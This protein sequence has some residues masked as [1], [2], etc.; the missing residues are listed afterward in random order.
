MGYQGRK[1]TRP[2]PPIKGFNDLIKEANK[3]LNDWDKKGIPMPTCLRRPA[4]SH[5][6]AYKMFMEES[7]LE[8]ERMWPNVIA[9]SGTCLPTDMSLQYKGK[10]IVGV[11]KSYFEY[12]APKKTETIEKHEKPKKPSKL[13]IIINNIKKAITV[14]KEEVKDVTNNS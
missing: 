5:D 14:K 7:K 4:M 2:K 8:S 3:T 6:E 12:D 11:P 1:P 13:S 9:T 10:R